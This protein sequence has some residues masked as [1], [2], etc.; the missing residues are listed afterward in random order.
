MASATKLLDEVQNAEAWYGTRMGK[1]E[2]NMVGQKHDTQRYNALQANRLLPWWYKTHG[3]P[4]LIFALSKD[5][6]LELGHFYAN[7]NS[8]LKIWNCTET[9]ANMASNSTLPFIWEYHNGCKQTTTDTV[10]AHQASSS[11]RLLSHSLLASDG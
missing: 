3:R 1:G 11:H 5:W 10:H 4:P 2:A 6:N 8:R 9:R 7:M